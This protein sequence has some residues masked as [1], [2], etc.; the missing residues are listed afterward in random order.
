M[1]TENTNDA[2]AMSPASAGSQPVA[3]QLWGDESDDGP[4]DHY[5]TERSAHWDA[6]RLRQENPAKKWFVV[7]LY[8]SPALT[9]EERD[10][11]TIWL[12]QCLRQCSATT[13]LG[14]GDVAERWR[15]R[16]LRAGHML[17]RFN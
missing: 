12:A 6:E 15:H 1:N 5:I 16:A 7:P 10:D 14:N 17:T 13:G 4:F 9:H 8:R 3:W 2:A 11:I